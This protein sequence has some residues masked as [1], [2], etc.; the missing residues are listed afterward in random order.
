MI[1]V[2]HI[3]GKML[4]GGVEAVVMNYYRHID[5]SRV[6][7]DFIVDSDSILVPRDEIESLGGRVFEV[8]PYQRLFAYRRALMELFRQEQWPIVHS[9]INALSAFPLQVAKKAGVPVRIAH[10]HSTA[11]KGEHAKNAIKTVLKCFSNIYPTHRFACSEYAGQWLFDKHADFEIIYN[12]IE[13]DRYSFDAEVRAETRDELGLLSN[14]F[15]I[16]H[17]GRFVT[18]KNHVF[19][20]YVFAEVL[21]R[22]PDAVLLLTGDGDLRPFIEHCAVERGIAEHVRF[23]GHRSDVERLYQAFD[24]FVLPS[25]YEGLGLV[26]VEAQRAGLP[27]YLSDQITREVDVTDS[28]NFLAIH[29]AD[30]W[31]DA[32]VG[33][34]TGRS[35]TVNEEVFTNYNIEIAAKKLT[36]KYEAMIKRSQ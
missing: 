27:C 16:G 25:L 7:F 9:H 20:I 29:N 12:A 13:L 14:Q 6:Q 26:A 4:G 11:G 19:L 36:E 31:A 30:S 15:V 23:L 32:L 18:Q 24:V 2:A 10:S 28:V 22:R 33:L 21:K 1:R 3:I 8:P 5:R 17:V 34:N 35:R